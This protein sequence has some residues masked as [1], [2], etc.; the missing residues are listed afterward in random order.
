MAQAP[1][2]LTLGTNR[3]RENWWQSSWLRRVLL[4]VPGMLVALALANAFG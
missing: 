4:L 3:D 1:Q 2:T